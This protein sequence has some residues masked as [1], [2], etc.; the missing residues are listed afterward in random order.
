LSLSKKQY[1]TGTFSSFTPQGRV[2]LTF[3][4]EKKEKTKSAFARDHLF[5]VRSKKD[6]MVELIK[7]MMKVALEEQRTY[8]EGR[9][10]DSERK[11]EDLT[12]QVDNLSKQV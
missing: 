9:I 8:Y 5:E 2:W 1:Q 10:R 11:I 6:E 7:T 4:D 12:E 3:E